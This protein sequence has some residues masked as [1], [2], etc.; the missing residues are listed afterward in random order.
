MSINRIDPTCRMYRIR[1]SN[2][3]SSCT[4]RELMGALYQIQDI[5]HDQTGMA[6]VENT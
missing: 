2:R 6:F 5:P 3:L 1:N 4:L